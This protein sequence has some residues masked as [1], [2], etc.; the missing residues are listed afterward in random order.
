MSD[1]NSEDEFPNDFNGLD[2]ST[3][4]GLE[5]PPAPSA[6]P[7]SRSHSSGSPFNP[8]TGVVVTPIAERGHTSSVSSDPSDDPYMDPR[9]LAAI[10][11]IEAHA[12]SRC[13]TVVNPRSRF[14]PSLPSDAML[15]QTSV[16]TRRPHVSTRSY[17]F[18]AGQLCA[19]SSIGEQLTVAVGRI[20]DHDESGPSSFSSSRPSS[21]PGPSKGKEKDGHEGTLCDILEEYEAEITCPICCDLLVAAYI[22]NPCGHTTCGECGFGWVSRNSRSPT[23]PVCR[24]EL[25]LPKP[26]LPNYTVDSLVKRHVQALAKSG[27]TEWQ[28]Q[29]HK[30]L[31]WNQRLESWRKQS[32]KRSA[33]E[34]VLPARRKRRH[35]AQN[36]EEHIHGDS[37]RRSM[38]N[39]VQMERLYGGQPYN[40]GHRRRRRT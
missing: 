9:L 17:S 8:R 13:H 16:R 4:P 24:S 30:S 34:S 38:D 36:S 14:Q 1:T 7:S 29:G 6:A 18:V 33:E 21:H 12:L 23:C 5:Q 15:G 19:S 3:I 35:R 27:L 26:L 10:D 40:P 28:K 2:L 31:E 11:E 25:T 39:I 37:S 22:T 32:A 20:D